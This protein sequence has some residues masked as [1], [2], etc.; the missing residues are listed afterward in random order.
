M[1]KDNDFVYEVT[2]N[3]HCFLI[4]LELENAYLEKR[5]NGQHFER[6]FKFLS[7]PACDTKFSMGEFF[8]LSRIIRLV[9]GNVVLPSSDTTPN[10]FHQD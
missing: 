10:K 9:Y 3:G 2:K 4:A 1:I 6:L 8:R 7:V 5:E